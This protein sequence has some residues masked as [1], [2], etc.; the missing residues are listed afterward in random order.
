MQWFET[1]KGNHH[2]GSLL[3]QDPAEL[4]HVVNLYEISEDFVTFYVDA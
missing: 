2:F 3:M 1:L 4:L